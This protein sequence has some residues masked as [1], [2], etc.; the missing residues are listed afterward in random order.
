MNF[1]AL[2]LCDAY[3]ACS[4]CEDERM[5]RLEEFKLTVGDLDFGG[6]DAES[7]RG[8]DNYFVETQHV[9]YLH[10]GR[11]NQLLGRKGSGKSALFRQI[12][13]IT[14]NLTTRPIV[15]LLT[16]NQYAWA[17]LRSYEEQ[18]LSTEQ[19]HTNAWKFTLIVEAVAALTSSDQKWTGAA[20]EAIDILSK[21]LKDNFGR[22]D[23]GLLN[24]ATSIVKGL[25]SFNLSAFG[26]GIGFDS[27]SDRQIITP[28]ILEELVT[29]LDKVV[30]ERP[31]IL[32]LDRLDDSWDGTDQAK[33]LM[34]GLLVAAKELNDRLG[35]VDGKSG[36]RVNVF[37]RSD[38]YDVL[39]FDEKDKHR[40]LEEWIL[41]TPELLRTMVNRRLPT[42]LGIDDVFEIGDMRGSISPF[43]YIVKRT[44]LRP[45]EV[46]QFLDEAQRKAGPTANA[47]SK[48]NIRA[49][50][51]RYSKWKVDDLRQEFDKAFPDFGRLLECLR[52]Q[53][54]RYD[55]IEELHKLIESR[56]PELAKSHTTQVLVERLFEYSVIGVRISNQGSTRFKSEDGDLTLPH[57][58]AVYIHQSLHK[59]LAITET[60]RA[61]D[62]GEADT[63]GAF[64]S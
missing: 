32:A 60:R 35:A 4:F 50:E 64:E 31:L 26:F 39:K 55:S 5:T 2:R 11:R 51:E 27:E 54:H 46:L 56:D 37:L 23:P 44:F 49:A 20:K 43:S 53:V 9:R 34:I 40:Q 48:D 25:S 22:V 45:R 52:Q 41:W 13:R 21:F 7:D 24:S 14:M 15:G 17:A 63:S 59:G 18:G 42:G 57:A 47:I 58:G 16:P 29:L 3:V 36:A 8:L 62:A 10:S 38:I 61:S 33:S 6:I 19:A 30:A 1:E 12:P 28:A